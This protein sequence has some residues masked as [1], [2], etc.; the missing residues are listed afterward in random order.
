MASCGLFA[1]I[2]CWRG[3]WGLGEF[4]MEQ[5]QREHMLN[6]RTLEM[7]TLCSIAMFIFLT[8]FF[9]GY[10]Q[11]IAGYSLDFDK[12][13]FDLSSHFL[14]W[15]DPAAGSE[16]RNDFL[17]ADS[18][19]ESSSDEKFIESNLS[20]LNAGHVSFAPGSDKSIQEANALKDSANSK[21]AASKKEQ[22]TVLQVSIEA[23]GDQ[24][25][26]LSRAEDDEEEVSS[27][28]QHK[29]TD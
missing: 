22:K 29:I 24:K 13:D 8:V 19:E 23:D 6:N 28:E 12:S 4:F 10:M 26:L 17:L 9:G 18:D 21:I 5:L 14:L 15:K 2:Q 7:I 11:N 27:L 16:S 1:S 20:N 3:V 25:P